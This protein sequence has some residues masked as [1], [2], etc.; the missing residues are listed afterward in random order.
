VDTRFDR[1][2]RFFGREGQERLTARTLAVVGIGGLGTHVVQ[3]CALLGFGGFSLIDHE[4]LDTTNLNRYVGVGPDD[5]GVQKAELGGRIVRAIN[6]AAKVLTINGRLQ[7]SAAFAAIRAADLVIACLDT[8]GARLVCAD[9][10]AAAGKPYVD[11]ATDIVSEDAIRYG[12]RIVCS[13]LGDGCIICRGIIDRDAARNELD[14][15]AAL[16]RNAIYGVPRAVMHDGI[17]PAVVSINGVVASLAVTEI[18]L[19]IT[20]IR[21]ARPVL[22]YRGELGSVLVSKDTAPARCYHCS[23]IFGRWVEAGVDKYLM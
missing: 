16:A 18:M 21:A 2:V 7:S 4:R 23:D 14:P 8:D 15:A 9:V 17:G 20:G 1:N 11:V 10:A 12:G 13:F 5:V 22:T 3:Q 19:H 6:P